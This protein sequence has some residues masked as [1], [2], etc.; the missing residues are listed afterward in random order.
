MTRPKRSSKV[1]ERAEKRM[2]GMQ[3]ISQELDLGNGFSLTG[4]KQLIE[5]TRTK[6]TTY[7]TL[8]SEVDRAMSEVIE[9]ERELG[10]FSEHMLLAVA[11]QY[12]K[13]SDE[14]EMAGGSKKTQQGRSRNTGTKAKAEEP[15]GVTPANSQNG[16]TPVAVTS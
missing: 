16:H 8:L 9:A 15:S 14:Y 6:L 12:G 7:N 3:S 5:K 2:A 4:F 10:D 11:I 1:L 13:G